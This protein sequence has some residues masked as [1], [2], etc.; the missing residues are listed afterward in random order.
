MKKINTEQP[1]EK[2]K[3][4]P[5][6]LKKEGRQEVWKLTNKINNYVK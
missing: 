5:V 3:E 6:Q 4:K 1:Q 2:K